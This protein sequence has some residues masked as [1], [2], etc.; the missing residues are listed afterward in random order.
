[1]GLVPFRAPVT[2]AKI[3]VAKGSFSV[4]GSR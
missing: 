3:L 2:I 4:R 1:V